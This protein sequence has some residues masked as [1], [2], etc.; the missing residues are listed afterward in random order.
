MDELDRTSVARSPGGHD[1]AVKVVVRV[2]P[3]LAHESSGNVARVDKRLQTVTISD[4]D[5]DVPTINRQRSVAV[6]TFAFDHAYDAGSTQAEVYE[7]TAQPVVE[8]CLQGYNATMFAYGQTGTGK[9]YT[10]DGSEARDP[11]ARGIIPR[12]VEQIFRHVAGHA[13]KNVRFL[14]R[15][16]CIQIYQEIVSD[17]LAPPRSGIAPEG[18]SAVAS[19]LEALAIRE[20]P[21]RGVYVDGLSEW[22][23]RQPSEVYALM[24]RASRSRATGATRMND[25]SSR[26][27]AVF[28]VI[29]EH[30]ETVYVGEDG[31]ELAPDDF[32]RE[33]RSAGLKRAEALA[34]LENRVKQT[35]RVGKL[36]LVDLAGSERVGVSGATGQRLEES[37]KI[38]ASLSALGNVIAAL[39]TRQTSGTTRKHVP[40]RDSKLTR[41]LE[42]SL[43]GNCRTTMLATISPAAESIA[44]TLSTLKFAMRAKRVTNVPRLNED[45][46]QASLLRKYE[47]EL[48]RLRA[49]LEERNRNVV[50]QRCLLELEE[51]RR[52]AE[53]DKRAAI[54]ALEVRSREFMREKEDKTRLEERILK[55]TSQM[56]S[57]DVGGNGMVGGRVGGIDDAKVSPARHTAAEYDARLADLERERER[58]EHEKAQVERYKQLLLKQRDIMIALT[59]R[60]N[61]RD[62][63]IMAL[64]DELEAYDRNQA[65]LENKLDE[66]TTQCIQIQRLEL[67]GGARAALHEADAARHDVTARRADN[68]KLMRPL[69]CA[70]A[71]AAAAGG[72][73]AGGTSA[74]KRVAELL[75][76]LEL[77]DKERHA[78]QT[79]FEKK[80]AVL[81]DSVASNLDRQNV[82]PGAAR[83]FALKDLGALRRLIRA[84]VE[85]LK[86]AGQGELGRRLA[87]SERNL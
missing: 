26:S 42:D 21:K 53:E 66:K 9:T 12:S 2:R 65:A 55:L 86:Q 72:A 60:L 44:E 11:V 36:N 46:D 87:T 24:D 4:V 28:V 31:R 82:A 10:M 7:T 57:T 41:L 8:S 59:Q 40:Y 67:E 33:M 1:D 48:R 25:F 77:R 54:R 38:N 15:A 5:N 62:E 71:A 78:V 13:Q 34:R 29:V 47:R 79:I 64:Q 43:G 75:T 83:A 56:I 80:I 22:V 63:Q 50:D 35:F 27:H 45:L 17:L 76:L 58:I 52:R 61:E 39:V 16:S 23:V 6:H 49:E 74:D 18:T 20:D 14:A 70:P 30:S 32:A 51:R 73:A 84:S 69:D 85:A 19:P 81:V 37:K 68:A 3:L